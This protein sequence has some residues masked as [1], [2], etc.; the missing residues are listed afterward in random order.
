[1]R[2]VN[3]WRAQA[4]FQ[5]NQEG[6]AFNAIN[7]FLDNDALSDW[8]WAWA[9]RLVSTHRYDNLSSARKSLQFW[10]RYLL[11]HP[12]HVHAQIEEFN[13]LWWIHQETGETRISFKEMTKLAEAITLKS[14]STSGRLWDQLGHWAQRE[15]DWIA[16]EAAF[17][18]A[19]IS[20]KKYSYCFA[21]ALNRNG[22]YEETLAVLNTHSESTASDAP[23][24][25]EL[26]VAREHLGDSVGAIAAYSQAVEIDPDYDV[27][28]F[29]LGGVFWNSG[30]M[31]NALLIWKAAIARFPAHE[32]ADRLRKDLPALFPSNE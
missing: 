2:L 3:A 9:A 17:R 32:A 1:M 28:H 13:C 27:A 22:K 26:A 20:D 8:E 24:Q 31:R 10:R 6:S 23:S 5:T 16:A 19:L 30:D 14:E 15:D 18:R 11:Q 12:G 29:N 21:R 25:F 4:L 7:S